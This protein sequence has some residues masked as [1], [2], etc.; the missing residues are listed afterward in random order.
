MVDKETAKLFL[1]K[2]VVI[3]VDD[4]GKLAFRHG[5]VTAVTDTTICIDFFG[6]MQAYSLS[7]VQAIR[8]DSNKLSAGVTDLAPA[9]PLKYEDEME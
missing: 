5:K 4:N 7:F 8:E 2:N 9:T 1:D 6:Q 3:T